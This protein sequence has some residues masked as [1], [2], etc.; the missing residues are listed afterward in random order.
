[1]YMYLQ[2]FSLQ[3]LTVQLSTLGSP[4]AQISVFPSK[5]FSAS[6]TPKAILKLATHT[7]VGAIRRLI[8]R[9]GSGA[10]TGV[11]KLAAP[12]PATAQLKEIDR[13][14]KTTHYSSYLVP[15][16]LALEPACGKQ[17]V[18]IPT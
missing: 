9:I 10:S 17:A 7:G 3:L 6:A 1:M 11:P 15:T 4:P 18:P 8:C 14:L 2:Y 16:K 12:H 13:S 5:Y